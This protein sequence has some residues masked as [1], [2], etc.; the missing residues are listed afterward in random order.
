M[1][2]DLQLQRRVSRKSYFPTLARRATSCSFLSPCLHEISGTTYAGL[3]PSPPITVTRQHATRAHLHVE[4]TCAKGPV[5][6]QVCKTCQ[7]IIIRAGKLIRK[8]DFSKRDANSSLSLSLRF[9]GK[10]KRD[11]VSA[12]SSCKK[13]ESKFELHL[14]F[15]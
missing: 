10:N 1:R 7:I 13:K 2:T 5:S 11:F 12:R 4:V 6:S 9:D 14:Q 3:N 15:E 8:V